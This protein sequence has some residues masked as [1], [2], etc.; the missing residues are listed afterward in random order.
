MHLRPS[1]PPSAPRARLRRHRRWLGR[2]DLVSSGVLAIV[3]F[4]MVN[5]LSSRHWA[6]LHSRAGS[7]GRLSEKTLRLLE[8]APGDIRVSVLMRPSNDAYRPAADLLREYAASSP[9]VTVRFIHP[10]RDLAD[11]E[12]LLRTARATADGECIVV[13][14]GGRHAAIPAETLFEPVTGDSPDGDPGP[15]RGEQLLTGAIRSLIRPSR[16]AVYFLQGHGEHSPADFGPIGYSRIAERLRDENAD[17]RTL[18]FSTARAIPADCELLVVAGPLRTLAPHEINLLRAHLD[19]RGRLLL[20]LDHRTDTGLEPL[21]R[22]WGVQTGSDVIADETHTLGGRDLH[23]NSY[24][25]HPVTASLQGL[26]TVFSLS[27]SLRLLPSLPAWTSPPSPPACSPPPTAG[28]NS[29]PATPLPASIPK[30]TSPA[31]SP[32][33]SPSNAVPCPASTSRYAPPA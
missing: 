2:A 21:L 8:E 13:E 24:P 1:S 14:T 19:R 6:R 23:A 32:S 15:F 28:P 20:L 25:S 5:L 16:P 17:V 29:N 30:S 11:A 12:S 26:S 33:P 9:A 27:R 4:G 3:L 22:D 18:D 31:P 10:D 7:A